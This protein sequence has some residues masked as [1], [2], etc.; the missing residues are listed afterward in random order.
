[1]RWALVCLTLWVAGG[2][3]GR[4]GCLGARGAEPSPALVATS[5]P[6][7]VGLPELWELALA[8]N[9]P[10]R[11]AAARLDEA[12]GR[13]VQAG[14]YPNPQAAYEEE[15]LGTARAAPGN[16]RFQV[17]QEIVTGGK[18]RLAMALGARATDAAGLALE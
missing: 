3:L 17:T 4:T 18:R 2:Q 11:E 6:E 14:K 10:L 1:M 12:R 5:P 13:Q 9:P 15:D 7:P 16:L 8:N